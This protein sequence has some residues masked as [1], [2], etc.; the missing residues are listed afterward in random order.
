MVCASE[1]RFSHA[2]GFRDN[3]CQGHILPR[4]KCGLTRLYSE[5]EGN[6]GTEA[7]STAAFLNGSAAARRLSSRVGFCGGKPTIVAP[8]K[9]IRI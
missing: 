1:P 4:R 3:Q 7:D 8:S 2:S 9:Q 6:Q 5:L